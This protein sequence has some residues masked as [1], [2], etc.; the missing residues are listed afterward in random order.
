MNPNG[1][2]LENV[3]WKA[4]RRSP[5]E[6]SKIDT[7]LRETQFSLGNFDTSSRQPRSLA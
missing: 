3:V 1:E 5:A 2:T 7:L 4:P 6:G